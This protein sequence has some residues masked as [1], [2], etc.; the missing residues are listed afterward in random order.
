MLGTEYRVADYKHSLSLE[1]SVKNEPPSS[2]NKKRVLLTLEPDFN[3]MSDPS[4]VI[5]LPTTT[6]KSNRSFS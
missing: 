1:Q 2:M 6:W 3:T 4:I 5:E